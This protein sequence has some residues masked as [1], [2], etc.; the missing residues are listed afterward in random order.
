MNGFPVGNFFA[1]AGRW[2]T[3]LSNSIILAC[4]CSNVI[5]PLSLSLARRVRKVD[6]AAI[7]VLCR[8]YQLSILVVSR[9]RR[10]RG[11]AISGL[12]NRYPVVPKQWQ[13]AVFISPSGLCHVMLFLLTVQPVPRLMAMNEPFLASTEN[14]IRQCLLC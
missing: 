7:I 10:G 13:V 4:N 3:D 12:Q 8:R 5:A 6:A 1:T 2:G 14:I 9:V 11:F